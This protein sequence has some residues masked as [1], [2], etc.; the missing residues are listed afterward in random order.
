MQNIHIFCNFQKNRNRLGLFSP[1]AELAQVTDLRAR[2]ADTAADKAEGPG[3]LYKRS[4]GFSRKPAMV[5][6]AG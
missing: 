5:R 6:T 2:D 4:R 1:R 3:L